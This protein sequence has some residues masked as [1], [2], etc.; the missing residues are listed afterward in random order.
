MKSNRTVLM[1]TVFTLIFSVAATMPV[2]GQDTSG[3]KPISLSTK[4]TDIRE[5]LSSIA[6]ANGINLIVGDSVKGM[7]TISL[8]NVSPLEAMELI[9]NANGFGMEK[10][11]QSIVA[12]KPEEI[13]NLTPSLTKIIFLQYA[14]ATELKQSLAGM[15]VSDTQIQV[16]P[17]TNSI[18]I[19]GEEAGIQEMEQ[20]IKLLD[21]EMPIDPEIPKTARIFRL[22]YAQASGLQEWVTGLLSSEGKAVTDEVTNS[23][24]VIDEPSVVERLAEIIA[25]LDAG[26][27]YVPQ[28]EPEEEEPEPQPPPELHTRVFNLNHIDANAIV[29]IIKDM[30]SPRGTVQIFVRQQGSISPIQATSSGSEGRSYGS[31]SDGGDLGGTTSANMKL[32]EKKWSDILI[33]TDVASGIANADELIKQLDV[34]APQVKIEA[35]V[36]ELNVSKG[37]ELGINWQAAHSTSDS[38]VETNFPLDVTESIDI[39]IGTFTVERFEDIVARVKALETSGEARIMFNPSI[40]ALDN[41]MAQML[42]ADKIPISRTFETEFRS[43]TGIEFINVGISLTV[44]PHTTEDGYIIMDAMPQVDSI[45]EWTKGENPQPIISSRVAHTRVRVKDGETFAISGLIKDEKNKRASGI[46][47]LRRIPLIG[48]LF[49]SSSDGST[50]TDLT[51]FIT[52]TIYKETP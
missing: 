37:N 36:V 34:R 31:G 19:T 14:Q 15:S 1:I 32:E 7:V 51:I 23:L 21:I 33:V 47:I 5:L 46:P 45:K 38:T 9:L 39:N 18:I 29:T 6:R 41:E 42:V 43:T 28:T 17:R 30:L 25:Q 4:D 20:V 35:K 49:G 3:G 10:A 8:T 13:K 24:A 48:R 2:R 16:N 40:I 22:Q 52:P 12:G 26:S 27:Q 50:K 44:I 11:G